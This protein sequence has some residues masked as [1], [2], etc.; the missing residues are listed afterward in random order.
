M[1]KIILFLIII[2][3][4]VSCSSVKVTNNYYANGEYMKLAYDTLVTHD[5]FDSLCVNESINPNTNK[6]SKMTVRDYETN[7]KLT[8]YMFIQKMDTTE[9]IFT[10]TVN[11]LNY[12]VTKRI[13]ANSK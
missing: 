1:K 7:E 5:G 4:A 8:K 13:T 6:W 10:L 11:D 3:I 12:K 2:F 9:I